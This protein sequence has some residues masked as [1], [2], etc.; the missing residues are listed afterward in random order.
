MNLKKLRL[1]K[2][3]S[4]EQLAEIT[5][6]SARTIQRIENGKTPGMETLKALAAGFDISVA[7][8]E[9]V[10]PEK[11]EAMD[12]TVLNG[13]FFG[14]IPKEWKG[15]ILHIVIFM[16]VMTWL[17]TLN[18]FFDLDKDAPGAAA[19]IWGMALVFHLIKVI[20]N[21]TRRP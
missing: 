4:Q 8:L 9:G 17:L 10:T 15:F 16:F 2:N 11:T 13:G 6:I 14:S 1:E 5:G 18:H 20:L 21:I 19:L 12:T 7:E 3:W